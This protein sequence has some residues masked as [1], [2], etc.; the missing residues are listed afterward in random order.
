LDRC[1]LLAESLDWYAQDVSHYP[2][3]D[4]RDLPAF[5]HLETGRRRIIESEALPT[6]AI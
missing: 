6:A 5:R 3:V 1:E 2:I 4:R